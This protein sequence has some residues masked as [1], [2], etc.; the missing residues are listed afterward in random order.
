[1]IGLILGAYSYT[2]FVNAPVSFRKPPYTGCSFVHGN[3][4]KWRRQRTDLTNI[5]HPDAGS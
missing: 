2:Y 3:E 5:I 4:V 1:M